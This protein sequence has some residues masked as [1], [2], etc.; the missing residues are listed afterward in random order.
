MPDKASATAPAPMFL[1]LTYHYVSAPSGW[2]VAFGGK[3]LNAEV[4]LRDLCDLCLLRS[5]LKIT[6][7]KRQAL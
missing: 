7:G 4:S 6:I 5:D 3:L 1:P 2:V